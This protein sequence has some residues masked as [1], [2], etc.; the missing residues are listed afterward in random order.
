VEEKRKLYKRISNAAL[1]EEN[2]QDQE[3][4]NRS[5]LFKQKRKS[6]SPVRSSKETSR[7]NESIRNSRSKS[8]ERRQVNQFTEETSEEERE[9]KKDRSLS[10]RRKK[11]ADA[12][13]GEMEDLDTQIGNELLFFIVVGVRFS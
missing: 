7:S 9:E 5:R 4:K 11:R 6:E 12:L 13:K 8:R 10:M 1:E 3:L 2:G